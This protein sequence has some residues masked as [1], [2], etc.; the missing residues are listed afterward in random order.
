MR[1]SIGYI[2]LLIIC[3]SCFNEKSDDVNEVDDLTIQANIKE[4]EF[5]EVYLTN[6]IAFSGVIDSLVVLKA[7]ELRAKVMISD[8]FGN[9][10]ILTLKADQTQYPYVFYQGNS[11]KGEA[12]VAYDIGIELDGKL[13]NSSTKIPL[14]PSVDSFNFVDSFNDGILQEGV[15]D[16]Q[17]ILNNDINEIQYYKFWVKDNFLESKFFPAKPFIVNTENVSGDTF[18]VLIEFDRLN[19]ETDEIDNFFVQG[20]ESL[21][22]VI[23]ITK[24]EYDFLKA[25]E[26]DETTLL[27]GVSLNEQIPSNILGGAFGYWSGENS[28][29]FSFEVK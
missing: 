16:L 14:K 3:M 26:G 15:K 18:S 25:I 1:L 22:D 10:E 28:F 29:Q 19:V 8:P 4:G 21:L 23:A 24:E 12:N 11:I 9:S 27:E 2:L 17:L 6:A 13:F 7:I 20:R 5:T